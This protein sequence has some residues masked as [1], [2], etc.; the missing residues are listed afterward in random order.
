MN[1]M[2]LIPVA[3]VIVAVGAFAFTGL[4]A[5]PMDDDMNQGN[6][7]PGGSEV[8]MPDTGRE[9]SLW[10]SAELTDVR[11]GET[12]RISD[13]EGQTVLLESFAVWCP[14]CLAQQKEMERLAELD[15]SII[16]IS[17]DTD[18][19]EDVTNVQSHIDRNGFDWLFAVAPIE[20]T[21]D[22]RNEFGL[23]VV[24]APSAPVILI[25]ENQDARL[26]RNGVKSAE[27]L[28]E[29]INGG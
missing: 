29:T 15:D 9:S 18:P 28:L 13:F 12:F 26:L 4:P 1:N 23:T 10:L 25:D 20:V 16:H 24:S 22:L 5:Q 27:E 19:N 3:I 11:T 21:Q 17:L 14:T 8:E 6:M 2:I 7:N